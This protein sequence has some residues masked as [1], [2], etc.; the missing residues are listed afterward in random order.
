M[1][2]AQAV[3]CKP[4]ISWLVGSKQWYHNIS[5]SAIY[6]ATVMS[7]NQAPFTSGVVSD[8]GASP[9]LAVNLARRQRISC[10]LSKVDVEVQT[11]L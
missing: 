3:Q 2:T 5:E 10:H 9:C 7:P 4:D 11:A 6:Q 8:N 1:I